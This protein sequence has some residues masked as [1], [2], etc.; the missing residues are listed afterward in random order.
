MGGWERVRG[1]RFQVSNDYDSK[2]LIWR[3]EVKSETERE[4]WRAMMIL[5]CVLAICSCVGESGGL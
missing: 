3:S 4:G 2:V 1:E 5:T